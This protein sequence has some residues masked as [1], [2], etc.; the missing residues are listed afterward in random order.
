MREELGDIWRY[1]SD[2]DVDAVCVATNM[3]VSGGKLIMGGGN[4]RE[5]RTRMP[6]LPSLWGAA[7]TL[8]QKEN[9]PSVLLVTHVPDAGYW[10]VAL[11]T[12]HHPSEDSDTKLILKAVNELVEV[13][14]RK[15]WENIILPRPGCG[16]GSLKW[17]D[18][19]ILIEPLLDD[20]FTVFGYA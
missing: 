19:R 7:Y 18:V 8:R 9:D 2:H 11:P 12:K 1:A 13:A 6:D 14:D 17:E 10:I 5:A 3:T 16:L 4:A 15:L 20:R